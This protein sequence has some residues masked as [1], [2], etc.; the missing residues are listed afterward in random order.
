MQANVPIHKLTYL[1]TNERTYTQICTY[2]HI[3]SY[4]IPGLV[5]VQS[6]HV[7]NKV[8]GVRAHVRACASGAL[9]MC[10]ALRCWLLGVALWYGMLSLS[11]YHFSLPSLLP[12]SITCPSQTMVTVR[13]YVTFSS[14]SSPARPFASQARLAG[15]DG[16]APRG[17]GCAAAAKSATSPGPR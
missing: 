5:G 17:G 16:A 15:I 14:S 2:T 9:S 12:R 8:C 3:C 7:R 6:L 4:G 10:L 11:R 1:Y 13:P